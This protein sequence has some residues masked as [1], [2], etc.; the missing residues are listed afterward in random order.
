MTIVL[1]VAPTGVA[2][3][4]INGTTINSVLAIPKDVGDT[5]PVMSD[6]TKTQLRMSLA[7]LKLIIIDEVFVVSNTTLVNYH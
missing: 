6:Q 3:V 5:L 4:N 7:E 1:L 2:V